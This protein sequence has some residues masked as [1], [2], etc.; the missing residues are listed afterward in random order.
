MNVGGFRTENSL[1]VYL[2]VT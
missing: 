1:R 2:E